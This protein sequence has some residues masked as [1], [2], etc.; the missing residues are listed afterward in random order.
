MSEVTP[1]N[2]GRLLRLSSVFSV[3]NNTSHS[4]LI[5]SQVS[6]RK[7]RHGYQKEYS[8]GSI[9]HSQSVP[10]LHIHTSG[11]MYSGGGG[12]AGGV[13]GRGESE[14]GGTGG[15]GGDFDEADLVPLELKGG[16]KYRVPL[17]LI[18][19][20]VSESKGTQPIF[21]PVTYSDHNHNEFMRIAVRNFRCSLHDMIFVLLHFL[22]LF[23][24]F[25][26]FVMFFEPVVFLFSL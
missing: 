20:S 15:E 2:G 10:Y 16:E 12:R 18:H 26:S 22:L 6:R 7:S 24:M 1:S 25:L 13:R 23:V 19:R 4:V 17:A 3:K 8:D 5:L 11:D 21:L 9:E 14:G